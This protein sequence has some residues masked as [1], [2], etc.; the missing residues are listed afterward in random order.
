MPETTSA[1]EGFMAGFRVSAEV[2][3]DYAKRVDATADELTA[4]TDSVAGGGLTVASFGDLGDQIGL[5]ASYARASELLRNQLLD[6]CA[7]LRSASDA[8]HKV[9]GHHSGGDA[10]SAALI[11]RAGEL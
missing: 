7:A 11:K 10:E 8:L 2:V 3:A 9:M 6:G 4:V 1:R 5:G